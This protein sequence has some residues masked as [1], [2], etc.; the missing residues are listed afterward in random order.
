MKAAESYIYKSTL[1]QVLAWCCWTVS[2]FLNQ[3]WQRSLGITRP[4]WVNS[5]R[6][7][8]WQ[9]CH[10]LSHCHQGGDWFSPSPH[11][12]C[13]GDWLLHSTWLVT[14]HSKE[15]ICVMKAVSYVHD[16]NILIWILI[17]KVKMTKF[18]K[19]KMRKYIIFRRV[20]ISYDLCILLYD[21][22]SW[23]LLSKSC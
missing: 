16:K 18:I 3:C 6:I 14:R 11:L 8:D 20:F 21:K 19:Y 10:S 12:C 2:Y 13:H 5:C 23:I 7:P 17:S 1:F 4:Q 9:S 15:G 22:H